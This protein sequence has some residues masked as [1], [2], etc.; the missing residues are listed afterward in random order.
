MFCFICRKLLN[1][2]IRNQWIKYPHNK[3]KKIQKAICGYG[4]TLFSPSNGLIQPIQTLDRLYLLACCLPLHSCK[5][6]TRPGGCITKAICELKSSQI[7]Q[8]QHA[9]LTAVSINNGCLLFTVIMIMLTH[10][11]LCWSARATEQAVL[12]HVH[13]FWTI[14]SGMRPQL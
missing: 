14:G 7:L 13:V 12:V 6:S 3:R 2:A 8:Y 9:S 4:R 10:T 5:S 1:Q 11:S